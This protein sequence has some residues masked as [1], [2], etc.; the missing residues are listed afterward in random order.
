M[1]IAKVLVKY[2]RKS[3]K[4]KKTGGYKEMSSFFADQ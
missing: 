3:S 4:S 2:A 1:E